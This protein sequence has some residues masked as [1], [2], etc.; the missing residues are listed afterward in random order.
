MNQ[1]QQHALQFDPPAARASDPS[2]S[3][4]AADAADGLRTRHHGEI[5]FAL[6]VLGRAGK[7]AIARQC[8]LTGVQVSRRLPELLKLGLIEDT[9]DKAASDSGRAE[10]QFRRLGP[11]RS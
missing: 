7:D 3:H 4:A 2:T 8:S 10:R 11:T 9:G 6:H 5:L 1:I